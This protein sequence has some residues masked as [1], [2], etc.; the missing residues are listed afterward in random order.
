MEDLLLEVKNEVIEALNL[1]DM[2]PE[3]LGDDDPL[4][5]ADGLG[6]DSIDAL[7][8][9]VLLIVL[10]EKKY[11]IKLQDPKDGKKVFKSVRVMAE[12]IQANR[13]K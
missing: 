11:G 4:F 10:L 12:F 13:T 8:L 1:E 9:I 5:G 7:E 6:L 3:D 2:T